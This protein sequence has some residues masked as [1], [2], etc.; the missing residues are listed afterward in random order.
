MDANTPTPP[1]GLR[2]RLKFAQ[3][4]KACEPAFRLARKYAR[5]LI[6]AFV[7]AVIAAVL[8]EPVKDFIAKRALQNASKAVAELI[9]RDAKGKYIATASGVFISPDGLLVTNAHVA[10]AAKGVT[11]LHSYLHMRFTR[12]KRLWV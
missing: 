10:T 6:I 12:L 7:L 5:E 1:K 9:I 11:S 8:Y 2:V 4:V 3:I